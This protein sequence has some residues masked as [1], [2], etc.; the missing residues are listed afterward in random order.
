MGCNKNLTNDQLEAMFT[1][2]DEKMRQI[3]QPVE[4]LIEKTK[5]KCRRCTRFLSNEAALKQHHCEPQ[6]KE[7]KCLHCSKTINRANNLEKHWRSCEKA[8]TQPSKRQLCQTTLDGPTSL[9]N[10]PS[11]PKNLML[12][13]VQVGGAIAEHGE[14]RKAP[15]IVKSA[16]K[17]TV[18]TSCSD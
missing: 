15:E 8:P 18:V 12:E 16:L 3:E 5:H 4:C 14:H 7:E 2:T 1:A 11:T 6:I 13:E 9:E 17:Y 10:G